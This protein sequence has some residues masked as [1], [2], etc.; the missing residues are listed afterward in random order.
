LQDY[1]PRFW[2]YEVVE[3][4][5]KFILT[6]AVLVFLPGS[7]SQLVVA[8]LV[9]MVTATAVLLMRPMAT[10]GDNN[11]VLV[12][13]W[14][15]WV[16]LFVGLLIRSGIAHSDHYDRRGLGIFIAA[17]VLFVPISAV[18][19]VFVATWRAAVRVSRAHRLLQSALCCIGCGSSVT[20][21]VVK[22]AVCHSPL[23]LRRCLCMLRCSML[24]ARAVH[25]RVG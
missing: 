15:L 3:L 4:L 6:S 13:N 9:S 19:A 18:I 20:L 8:L 7:A 22:C 2:Y 21:A 14:S 5:R 17:V 12:S 1:N 16:L 25:K 23:L 10:V 11:I 24:R